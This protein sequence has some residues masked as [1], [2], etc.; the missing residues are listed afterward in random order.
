MKV[1]FESVAEVVAFASLTDVNDIIAPYVK[2]AQRIVK[3]WQEISHDEHGTFGGVDA[4]KSVDD[5]ATKNN[6]ARANFRNRYGID[7]T[8]YCDATDADGNPHG[9]V[10]PDV[11]HIFPKALGGVLAERNGQLI[12]GV[13]EC[14][15]CNRAKG[16]RLSDGQKEWLYS[17]PVNI[18]MEG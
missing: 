5:V 9:Y 12:N 15:K 4:F 3:S 17:M 8:I 7:A 18:T 11:G 10:K 2:E 1:Q 16:Q 6:P 14:S 13:A